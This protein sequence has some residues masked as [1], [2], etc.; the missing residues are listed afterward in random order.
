V[1]R[2]KVATRTKLFEV[3]TELLGEKGFGSTT[4]DE[5]AELAGVAKGTIYYH[6][7]SKSELVET[8]IAEGLEPLAEQMR[9][10]A[11]GASSAR[12]ALSALARVELAFI[13][14]HTAF[15][16]LVMTELWREDRVWRETLLLLRERIGVVIREQVERG[17]AAG[18]LRSDIDPQFA[19]R[20]LFALTATAAL[21]W[22]AFEPERPVEDVVDQ[23]RRLTVMA[24]AGE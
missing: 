18:E 2:N 17:I 6:F 23:I 4:V 11:K 19:A 1:G 13:R 3:A 16:K 10:A 24:V 22:L 21:D 12:D 5:I 7:D 8:L 20:A 9:D 15:A 14:D